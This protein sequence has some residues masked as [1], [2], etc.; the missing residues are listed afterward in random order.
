MSPVSTPVMMATWLIGAK[1]RLTMPR[2]DHLIVLHYHIA[3]ARFLRQL[4]F[5][6]RQAEKHL[7][8]MRPIE[9]VHASASIPH[10]ASIRNQPI[11]LLYADSALTATLR[12]MCGKLHCPAPLPKSTPG[13]SSWSSL[14]GGLLPP[15]PA[16]TAAG[17]V[18][19]LDT[20]ILGVHTGQLF[21]QVR[22]VLGHTAAVC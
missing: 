22:M 4:P 15:H 5:R 7:P 2:G 12:G 1:H 13:P 20:P 16:G 3:I 11:N 10:V 19:L 9:E 17:Y 18:A 6:C 8:E 14:T 21:R